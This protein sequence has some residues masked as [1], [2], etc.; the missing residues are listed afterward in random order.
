MRLPIKRRFRLKPIDAIAL[1]LVGALGAYLWTAFARWDLLEER[2]R[3]LCVMQEELATSEKE[4]PARSGSLPHIQLLSHEIKKLES[5]QR[6]AQ[7][8]ARLAFLKSSNQ[9]DFT[10]HFL[11]SWTQ[12]KLVHPVEV[13]EEDLKRLLALIEGV[14]IWPYQ[15]KS[16]GKIRSIQDFSLVKKTLPS[17]EKV[18]EITIDVLEE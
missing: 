3:A 8:E 16:G 13:D 12:K 5:A 11:G 6:S 9:I 4:L 18:Y 17:Q 15:S 10:S 14:G 1:L 2:W 7:Q